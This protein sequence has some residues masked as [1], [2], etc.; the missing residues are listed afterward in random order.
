MVI[1]KE[2]KQGRCGER[3]EF[4]EEPL[5]VPGPAP[6]TISRTVPRS[7]APRGGQRRAD[8]LSASPQ[9]SRRTRAESAGLHGSGC[10]CSRERNQQEGNSETAAWKTALAVNSVD[11][12][13]PAAGVGGGTPHT[14]RQGMNRSVKGEQ[15]R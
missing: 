4:S 8:G 14:D 15:T 13:N 9:Q 12:M 2:V 6:V 1:K 5:P 11:E 7:P 10:Q 3:T